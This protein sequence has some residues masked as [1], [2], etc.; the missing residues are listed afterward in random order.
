METFQRELWVKISKGLVWLLVK[1]VD[2]AFMALSWFCQHLQ[3]MAFAMDIEG[4]DHGRS[5][6]VGRA[7][8][9]RTGAIP[10]AAPRG[11]TPIYYLYGYVPPNRV[12]ILKV[13][14]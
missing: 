12:V 2:H 13:L 10:R 11:G 1:Y 5:S 7:F 9:S 6:S 8:D 4:V 14:I 3:E